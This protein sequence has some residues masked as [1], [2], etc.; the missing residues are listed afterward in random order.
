MTGISLGS[1]TSLAHQCCLVVV[2][3]SPRNHLLSDGIYYRYPVV[4]YNPTLYKIHIMYTPCAAN[5]YLCH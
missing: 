4:G 1:Q 5:K 3:V 2:Y